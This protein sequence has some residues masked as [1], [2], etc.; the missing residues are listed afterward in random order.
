M[1][2]V[3]YPGLKRLGL[4][5]NPNAR[6]RIGHHRPIDCGPLDSDRSVV[7]SG[8][9]MLTHDTTEL[10]LASA[11][12]A[13]SLTT[14]ATALA[15]VGRIDQLDP[16]TRP[17]RLVADKRAQLPKGPIAV[18]CSLLWPLNP[19]PLADTAQ[20]FERNRP[21]HPE[22]TR[23]GFGNET[24]AD[25]VICIFLKTPLSASELMQAAFGRFR[26]DLLK[27]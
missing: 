4:R 17:L 14:R 21:L 1:L 23:F 12:A 27:Y 16:Y 19:R 10:G 3:N 6:R 8:E 25:V 9:L 13:R 22:G 18:P 11:V 5:L 26:S 2:N 7:I 20:V 15:G 24:L